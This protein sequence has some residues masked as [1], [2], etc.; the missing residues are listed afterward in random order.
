[1][2]EPT[3]D[4]PD[5]P[6]SG[7]L[8]QLA[9]DPASRKRFLKMVGGTGAAGAF[10]IFLAACGSSKK[11]S[12]PA[13]TTPP[14]SSS[15]FGSGDLGIVK[16]ALTLEYL[17]AQFYK[18]AA[19]SGMLKGSALELGKKFGS[20]EAQHVAALEATV[21]K[22]GGQLPPKPKGK[23]P[24]TS[25]MAILKLAATVENL[26]A[27]AYLGQAANIQSPE[28]LASALAIHSVEGRHAA[29]LNTLLGESITPDGAFAKPADVK[30]VLKSVE[31]F[32]VE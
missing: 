32:L 18:D 12:A 30:T 10:S 4:Q 25:E 17:E 22:L 9:R 27:A 15:K 2:S 26:G 28:V 19:A 16:Y 7:A 24:L 13:A 11:K 8:E 6:G 20:Q 14:P 5:A 23:F 29:T 1:M 3:L 31:P 21:K